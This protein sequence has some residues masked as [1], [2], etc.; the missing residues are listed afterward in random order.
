MFDKL[1]Q[2]RFSD[3]T[4]IEE[5]NLALYYRSAKHILI[6][7]YRSGSRGKHVTSPETD[8]PCL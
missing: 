6:S 3:T 2:Y 1:V 8:N 7:L 5:V 4:V